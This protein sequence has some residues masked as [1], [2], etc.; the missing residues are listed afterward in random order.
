[1]Q[2]TSRVQLLVGVQAAVAS[3]QLPDPVGVE[4]PIGVQSAIAGLRLPKPVHVQLPAGVQAAIATLELPDPVDV[5]HPVTAELYCKTCKKSFKT[6]SAL[7][8]HMR[9]H[10]P[11][12]KQ[13]HICEY[14]GKSFCSQ[15]N[16]TAHRRYRL[17]VLN[18]S[19]PKLARPTPH[20]CS[21]DGCSAAFT[22][23]QL[24]SA[25]ESKCPLKVHK[26]DKCRLNFKNSSALGKHKK[27]YCL[28]EKPQ[29]CVKHQIDTFSVG[30]N[31][32]AYL[33]EIKQEP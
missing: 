7:K 25:H 32:V 30:C 13:V 33:E 31:S 6:K 14:C 12:A 9:S 19:K 16:K 27:N 24:R 21:G 11:I 17:H 8:N 23:K 20:L 3:V 2:N 18:C 10:D 28:G 4:L 26:C 5:Q 1:M 22:S 15:E 29:C